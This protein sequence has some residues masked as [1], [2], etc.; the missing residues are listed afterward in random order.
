MFR[1]KNS[2]ILRIMNHVVHLNSMFIWIA[3]EVFGFR[4]DS[5]NN[6]LDMVS[7]IRGSNAIAGGTGH[8]DAEV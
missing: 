6:I 7:F 3:F 5:L 4:W 8:G 2:Y 1:K